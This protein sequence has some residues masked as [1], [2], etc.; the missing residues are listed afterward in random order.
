MTHIETEAGRLIPLE[1]LYNTRD[2]GG[3]E[4]Q[5]KRHVRF[6]RLYR[7]GELCV[8]SANDKAALEAWGIRTIVDFRGLSEARKHPDIRPLG[9]RQ[10]VA[11]PIDAGSLL[12]LSRVGQDM[13]GEAFMMNLYAIIV[14]AARPQYRELFRLMS[15]AANTPLLF[16]CSAGKDRTGVAAALIYHALGVERETIYADYLLSAVYLKEHTKD[17]VKDEPHLEPV[18]SIRR[19]YLETAFKVIDEKFGGADRYVE[20]ELGAESVR[21][22]E[23]YTE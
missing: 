7:A 1:K 4:T 20:H 2:L 23:L 18:M 19:E 6:G 11:L 21:L 13:S 5:D 16:H 10:Q 8:A 22:R 15:D 12:E 17:W 3:Y 14:E 9:L